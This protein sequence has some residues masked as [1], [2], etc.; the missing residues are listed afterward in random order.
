MELLVAIHV[1]LLLDSLAAETYKTS[2]EPHFLH[3]RHLNLYQLYPHILKANAM[4][5]TAL[6]TQLLEV[7]YE[8]YHNTQQ[9]PIS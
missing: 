3:F 6:F 4:Q 1:I 5:N 9:Q 2:A 8:A 7:S